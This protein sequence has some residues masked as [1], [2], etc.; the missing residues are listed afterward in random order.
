MLVRII[1]IQL[2]EQQF[3]QKA[4]LVQTS[5]QI[6]QLA[7]LLVCEVGAFQAHAG[8]DRQQPNTSERQHP[9]NV[10]RHG[11]ENVKH[12]NVENHGL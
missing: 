2:I 8:G 3:G 6:L 7:T 11:L 4:L 5:Q 1:Q 9:E 10:E 12:G